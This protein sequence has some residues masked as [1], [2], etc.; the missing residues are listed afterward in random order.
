MN[1]CTP[2]SP[3]PADVSCSHTAPAA[4]GRT[5]RLLDLL[6]AG[7]ATAAWLASTLGCGLRTVYRE[8][9]RLRAHGWSVAS[10]PGPHGG[11]WLSGGS[12]PAST[13]LSA[14]AL[15]EVAL[16]LRVLEGLQGART[17]AGERAMDAVLSALAPSDRRGVEVLL[18]GLEVAGA[19][20]APAAPLAP[21]ST[22]DA[23]QA[24]LAGRQEILCATSAGPERFA[25]TGL[26]F[27]NG[28]WFAVGTGLRSPG[29]LQDHPGMPLPLG[30]LRHVRV[31]PRWTDRS[32]R[33]RPASLPSVAGRC[34]RMAPEHA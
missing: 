28:A 33:A 31:R 10:A 24:A 21:G 16:A 2:T 3:R 26:A 17:P 23:I 19:S 11:F 1:R 9:A 18:G 13:H 29:R 7:R 12:R 8:V 27:R 5:Q 22:L 4:I 15:R 34:P 25:P 6:C 30:D 32:W 14:H 20:A